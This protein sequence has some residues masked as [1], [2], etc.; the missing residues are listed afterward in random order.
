[1]HDA[2][3]GSRQADQERIFEEFQ[4]AG[5]PEPGEG[6]GLGLA[7]SRRLAELHGG[8]LWVESRPGE[9]S[10]F[11][12]ALPLA[13]RPRPAASTMAGEL[14]LIVEDNERNMSLAARRPALEG[15]RTLEAASGRAALALAAP[16]PPDGSS[17][18]S[19][20]PT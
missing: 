3:P 2:G 18:T 15:F 12:L 9:G 20:L 10:T 14:I 4:Q 7:L 17:W 13:H 1:M 11:V 8:R 5:T 19:G 16:A 6:T